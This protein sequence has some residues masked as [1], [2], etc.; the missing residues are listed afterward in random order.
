MA[1][2]TI[3]DLDEI[4]ET[5]LRLRA[6]RYGR[7][8]EDEARKILQ[9]VLGTDDSGQDLFERIRAR[10]EPLGG[11]DLDIPAR[12]PMPKPINFNE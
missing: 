8:V 12:A 1:T 9:S 11:V 6:E 4:L 10:F 5:R 2:V 7:S 3:H